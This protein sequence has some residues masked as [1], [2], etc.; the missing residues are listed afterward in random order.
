VE[1]LLRTPRS[2]DGRV[3]RYIWHNECAFCCPD[4]PGRDTHPIAINGERGQRSNLIGVMGHGDATVILRSNYGNITIIADESDEREYSMSNESIADNKEQEKEGS[5]TWEGGFGK[6]RFRAQW[7]RGP[8][9]A[10][11]HFQGPFTDEDPDGIGTA[12]SPDFGFEW[13]RGRGARVFGEYDENRPSE[14]HAAPLNAPNVMHNA[15]PGMCVTRIGMLWN[16]RSK[17]WWRK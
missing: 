4:F 15:R 10:R 11:F 3:F 7:D 8:K 5:R 13:E 12:F 2:L 17:K 1:G 14:L 9:H 6:H 16:M